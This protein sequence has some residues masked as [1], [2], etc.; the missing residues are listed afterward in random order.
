MLEL[1]TTATY[2]SIHSHVEYTNKPE[3][4]FDGSQI[5]F[6]FFEA[7]RQISDYYLK[8]KPKELTFLEV[9]AWKGLWGIAF[10]EF[11]KLNGIKGKY[12]TIT[13]L[14]HDP[15]NRPL[16]DTL[17]YLNYDGTNASLVDSNTLDEEALPKVLE[18]G[19]SFNIVFI[20]AG[21]KYYEVMS[22]INKFSSLAKDILMFHDIRPVQVNESC[23]VYKALKDLDISL[24]TEIV[25]DNGWMGIGIKFINP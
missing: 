12:I 4:S 24:D 7:W 20:D 22:D 8:S 21:H 14:D 18:Q 5:Q 3:L 23:G 1:N 25:T 13:K 17:E 11:C 9:G 2:S 15:N 6:E 10:H 16:L 19:E